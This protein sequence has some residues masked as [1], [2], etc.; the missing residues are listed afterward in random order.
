MEEGNGEVEKV[1]RGG[2]ILP[3][4][5]MDFPRSKPLLRHPSDNHQPQSTMPVP[6]QFYLQV[7]HGKISGVIHGVRTNRLSSGISGGFAPPEPAAVK[8][9]ACAADTNTLQ[10]SS[11][12]SSNLAPIS[13]EK[14]ESVNSLVEELQSILKSIPTEDPPASEDIYGL[15]TSIMWGSDDFM[16]RNA[17]PQGCGGQS[18]VQATD[19]QKAKFKRALEI[20]DALVAKGVGS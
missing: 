10:I 6:S 14:D 11:S 19:E 16:W 13:V 3:S 1:N 4:L 15:N 8:S 18:S 17:G 12:S 2:P 5:I 7:Q 20:A 9:V